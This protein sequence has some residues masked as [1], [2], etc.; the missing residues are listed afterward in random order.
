MARRCSCVRQQRCPARA[1]PC[2]G[3]GLLLLLTKFRAQLW[4]RLRV[5]RATA[6]ARTPRRHRGLTARPSRARTP[7]GRP[8][9]TLSAPAPRKMQA[10]RSFV[11]SFST[12]RAAVSVV[13]SSQ[14]AA[15]ELRP[16]V[17]RARCACAP[18]CTAAAPARDPGA[19]RRRPELS[20]PAPPARRGR[21]RPLPGATQRGVASGAVSTRD[22]PRLRPAGSLHAHARRAAARRRPCPTKQLLP[23]P[24]QSFAACSSP[25]PPPI[26]HGFL[27]PSALADSTRGSGHGWRAVHRRL[28]DAHAHSRHLHRRRRLAAAAAASAHPRPCTPPPSMRVHPRLALPPHPHT[29]PPPR[30]RPPAWRCWAPRAASASR[31]RC[32]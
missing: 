30:R 24:A 18:G 22:G 17:G 11:R 8:A 6:P 16:C 19:Q 13:C 27:P 2:V 25:H 3:A 20:C 32:C 26:E 5:K 23:L 1:Q 31:C 9:C 10:S 28:D 29:P 7:P 14:D 12:S 15:R 21:G 4:L